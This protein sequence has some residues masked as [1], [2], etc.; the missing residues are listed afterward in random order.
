MTGKKI[1]LIVLGLFAGWSLYAQQPQVK[2]SS[3]AELEKQIIADTNRI[4]VLN[5]WATWCKPCVEELPD[6]EQIHAEYPG[7]VRVILANLD[8]HSKVESLVIPFIEKRNLKP[9]V[10]HIT[11]SDPNE[12]ID[13]VTTEWSGAIP[14]T[15]IFYKGKKV[16]FTG[17]K[18]DH[19]TLQ[20]T[21]TKYLQ[22]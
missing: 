11:D 5:F 3:Y 9:E 16:W 20:T 2:Y 15:I 13:L 14:A 1:Y 7:T 21:I 22:P 10:I 19:T 8:F 18:T 17:E 4:T 12:W 6:F